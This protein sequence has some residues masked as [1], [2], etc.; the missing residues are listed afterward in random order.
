[1]PPTSSAS[2]QTTMC[3]LSHSAGKSN[4][5]ASQFSVS[6]W[7]NRYSPP[8]QIPERQGEK[9]KEEEGRGKTV[10]G[11]RG[12]GGGR[13]GERGR[14]GEGK[15]KAGQEEGQKEEEVRGSKERRGGAGG[16]G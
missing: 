1:M 13:R 9:E 5:F 2:L 10:G 3:L 12:G 16:E 8:T 11:G 14:G 4:D 6:L 7:I 15:E